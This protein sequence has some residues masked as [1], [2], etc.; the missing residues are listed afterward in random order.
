MSVNMTF[1]VDMVQSPTEVPV[2]V[3]SEKNDVSEAV[4]CDDDGW[5]GGQ[6]HKSDSN[7]GKF[8]FYRLLQTSFPS[9][10]IV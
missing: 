2:Q 10:H 9:V 8:H 3:T 6:I 5:G 7:Q 1:Q 4:N